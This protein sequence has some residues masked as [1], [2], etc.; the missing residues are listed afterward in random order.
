MTLFLLAST[1]FAVLTLVFLVAYFVTGA[2]NNN[3]RYAAGGFSILTALMW[4][5]KTLMR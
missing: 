1:L 4:L 2:K 3:L 5:I